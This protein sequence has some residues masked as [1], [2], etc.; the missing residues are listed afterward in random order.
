MADALEYI[1]FVN[2]V[3]PTA[4]LDPNDINCPRAIGLSRRRGAEEKPN[5]GMKR[6]G[7][8]KKKVPFRH[9]DRQFQALSQHA[10]RRPNY[11]DDYFFV[12]PADARREISI[13]QILTSKTDQLGRGA[14][15]TVHSP[16]SVICAVA[17]MQGQ[18]E[19]QEPVL[20]Y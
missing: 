19:P 4:L 20:A 15:V 11:L 9:L 6:V 10:A 5:H 16:G 18:R 8:R 7:T 2:G 3:G 14:T 1:L 17:A 13:V 12:G